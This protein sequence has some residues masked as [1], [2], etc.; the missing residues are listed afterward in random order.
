MVFIVTIIILQKVIIINVHEK[1]LWILSIWRLGLDFYVLICYQKY[2]LSNEFGLIIDDI[3][4]TNAFN[5]FVVI[6]D[7]IKCC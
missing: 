1:P 2:A 3:D 6:S 5:I 4:D 7:L